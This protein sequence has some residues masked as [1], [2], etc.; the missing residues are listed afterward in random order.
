MIDGGNITENLIEWM[1]M[2]GATATMEKLEDL[3]LGAWL[4]LGTRVIR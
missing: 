2:A 4:G 1:S 3:G